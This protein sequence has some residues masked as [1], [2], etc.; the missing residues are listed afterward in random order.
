MSYKEKYL[1]YKTKY[2][3]LK[4]QKGGHFLIG[5]DYFDDTSY[6]MF[7]FSQEFLEKK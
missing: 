2:S 7:N 1:K 5:E 3:L 4:E 6:G